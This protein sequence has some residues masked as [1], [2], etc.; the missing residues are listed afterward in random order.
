MPRFVLNLKP[1]VR[2]GQVNLQIFLASSVVVDVIWSCERTCITLVFGRLMLMSASAFE[3]TAM[4][5]TRS[6]AREMPGSSP[7][8]INATSSAYPKVWIIIC[9]RGTPLSVLESCILRMRSSARI[10]YRGEVISPCTHH[11][12]P[13]GEDLRSRVLT[14]HISHFGVC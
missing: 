4:D 14:I 8:S 3:P 11:P 12:T 10:K 1:H 2:W 13:N 7:R 5:V 6:V 9:P